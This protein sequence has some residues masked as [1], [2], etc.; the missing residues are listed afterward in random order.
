MA[1]GQSTLPGA[2]NPFRMGQNVKQTGHLADPAKQRQSPPLYD[3]HLQ[4][5]QSEVRTDELRECDSLGGKV[6][7]E[8]D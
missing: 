3:F 2:S 5:V 8:D 1:G 4:P 7:A 6:S